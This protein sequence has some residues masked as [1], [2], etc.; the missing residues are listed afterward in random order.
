MA[1]ECIISLIHKFRAEHGWIPYRRLEERISN[2]DTGFQRA[3][4][5]PASNTSVGYRLVCS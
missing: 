4:L 1:V 3:Y 2:G 5:S